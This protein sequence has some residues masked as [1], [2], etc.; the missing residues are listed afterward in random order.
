MIVY[1]WTDELHIAFRAL[2]TTRTVNTRIEISAP[3]GLATFGRPG[4]LTQGFGPAEPITE[5]EH[6]IIP[7]RS[8]TGHSLVTGGQVYVPKSA[9]TGWLELGFVIL[10][11][12]SVLVSAFLLF[13]SGA[14]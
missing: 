4:S 2:G 10:L 5:P 14:N 1:A 7:F 3:R 11:A 12:L 8:P 9:G 13:A 6:V